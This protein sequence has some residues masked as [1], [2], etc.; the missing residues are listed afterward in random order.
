MKVAANVELLGLRVFASARRIEVL[1]D[2]EEL[3]I[4]I[5]ALDVTDQ[6][7]I[8]ATQAEIAARTGG[9][10][11]IL[12][13]NAYVSWENL[14]PF[15]ANPS[16]SKPA[17]KVSTILR[18]LIKLFLSSTMHRH[19]QHTQVLPPISHWKRFRACS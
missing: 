18:L 19:A 6:A 10:L 12:V 3:G 17:A 5:F 9:K 8:K 14:F 15:P 1:K 13:N 16:H 2:L 7:A 4:E 11:D